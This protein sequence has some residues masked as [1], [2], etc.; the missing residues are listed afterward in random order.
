MYQNLI[1]FYGWIIFHCIH[2]HHIL[3]IYLPVD[4]HLGFFDF[5]AF[6]NNATTK[7]GIQSCVQVLILILLDTYLGVELLD[8]MVILCLTFW[9]TAKLIEFSSD[10]MREGFLALIKSIHFPQF[11]LVSGLSSPL[12]WLLDSVLS[13]GLSASITPHYVLCILTLLKKYSHNPN[14]LINW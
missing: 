4:G 9:Q 14:C 5:L 12:F 10:E 1:V 6:M 7:T 3:F 13:S 2:I 11:L 8:H